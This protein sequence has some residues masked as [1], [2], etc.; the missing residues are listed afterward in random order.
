MPVLSPAKIQRLVEQVMADQNRSDC[1]KVTLD[2]VLP[3]EVVDRQPVHQGQGWLI[4]F[5]FEDGQETGFEIP[6]D[7]DENWFKEE[8]VRHLPPK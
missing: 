2:P 6:A 1:K 8:V 7:K 5:S 3:V 4:R